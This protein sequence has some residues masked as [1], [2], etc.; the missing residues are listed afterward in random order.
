M[1]SFRRLTN[2]L[3]LSPCVQ[4]HDRIVIKKIVYRLNLDSSTLE[5][6]NIK[7]HK[8]IEMEADMIYLLSTYR[9]LLSGAKSS[10]DEEEDSVLLCSTSKSTEG[11][12]LRSKEMRAKVNLNAEVAVLRM[13]FSEVSLF[14]EELNGLARVIFGRNAKLEHLSNN[15]RK[16]LSV[17]SKL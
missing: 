5:D 9:R 16:E 7:I 4:D 11:Y 14:M 3:L 6:I 15:Y 13:R 12:K 2:L 8:Q 1:E 17:D 10:L